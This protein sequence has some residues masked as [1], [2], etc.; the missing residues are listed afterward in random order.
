MNVEP[1]LIIVNDGPKDI[2]ANF[3]MDIRLIEFPELIF[4]IIDLKSKL[5]L[6][7]C[8]QSFSFIESRDL[9]FFNFGLNF[10]RYENFKIHR[11]F[12]K[13]IEVLRFESDLYCK[14][15]ELRVEYLSI[16]QF[17]SLI[18]ISNAFN[19]YLHGK[20]YKI[21]IDGNIKRYN[22]K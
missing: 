3:V 22:Y 2:I 19:S 5:R 20:N 11:E 21:S 18:L 7:L 13:G 15:G 9:S 8:N 4:N 16:A 1:R 10:T 6:E 17:E 14:N 12:F